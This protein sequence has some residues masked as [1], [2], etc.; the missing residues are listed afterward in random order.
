LARVSWLAFCP[1][2]HA[3]IFQNPQTGWSRRQFRSTTVSMVEQKDLPPLSNDGPPL[4][5]A[6]YMKMRE[7]LSADPASGLSGMALDEAT[8][9]PSPPAML[10]MPSSEGSPIEAPSS[11]FESALFE[12]A[13]DMVS[14]DNEK[15]ITDNF[16]DLADSAGSAVKTGFAIISAIAGLPFTS[17]S[18]TA[19]Y[20]M[21]AFISTAPAFLVY[22]LTEHG[23]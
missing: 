1:S 4:S 13:G 19:F 3:M 18:T 14:T 11:L 8:R 20:V 21:I 22:Y 6:E 15:K 2:A 5:F 17:Q 12:S 16:Q 9:D 23:Y 10:G 7:K